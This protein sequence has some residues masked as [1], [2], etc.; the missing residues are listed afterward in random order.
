MTMTVETGWTLAGQP[1]QSR[2]FI[3][4]AQYP[5]PDIM[6]QAILASSADVITVS[7]R[8]QAAQHQDGKAFWDYVKDL[9]KT[10]LPNTAGCR[11]AREAVT[12]AQMAREV[13]ATPW[14]KLE[15]IGDDYN[16]QPDPFGLVE[17]AAILVNEGFV[18]FPYCT[19]DLVLCQKLVDIGCEILM[20][21]AAPIGSAQGVLDPFALKTLRRRLPDI[22]LIVD[23]GLG[24]PSQ[25]AQVMEMG[26]DGVLLNSA[27]ALADAPVLM[28]QGFALAVQ[29]GRCAFLAGPLQPRDMASPSTPTLGMPFWHRQ[30]S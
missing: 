10:L 30:S 16:L 17:A 3:G 9:G 22:P 25:A 15:V 13:F 4:T 2:L 26:F 5:S 12:F 28:A 7:L 1:L 27:I 6:R 11:T 21:W 8:R 18:V 24:L 14:I 20:P 23:A 29:A 19:D